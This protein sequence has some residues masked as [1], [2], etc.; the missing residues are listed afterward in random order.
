MEQ[1]FQQIKKEYDLFYNS[2][3][4]KGQLPMGDTDAGFWGASVSEDVFE[5]FRKIKLQNFR[6]FIDLGS[7]DGKVALIASLF[8]KSA[9]IEF[10][11][12]LHRKAVE[13]RDRLKLKAELVKGDFLKHDL[14][15]Y[16]ILFINPDKSFNKGLEKK[17]R[18]EMKGV[19]FVYNMI[20]MPDSMKKGKTYWISSVPITKYT[21]G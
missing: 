13:I 6:H 20:Y 18:K 17:L 14:S 10:D 21:M 1:K 16:D 8:T 2:L 7:G 3:L 4:R 11:D 15:K 9:G 5:F 12:D 19:L